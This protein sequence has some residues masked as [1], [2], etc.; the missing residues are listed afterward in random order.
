MK[1]IDWMN[2]TASQHRGQKRVDVIAAC[3]KVCK[4]GERNAYYAFKKTAAKRMNSSYKTI[5]NF[6]SSFDPSEKIKDVID[7]LPDDGY[8]TEHELCDMAGVGMYKLSR[9]KDQFTDNFLAV[10]D[11]AKL[12][13][14]WAK[15]KMINEMRK[16]IS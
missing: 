3:V 16:A 5:V 15:K 6:K 1:A 7:S 12:S 4:C 10:R 11:G 2:K 9:Y 8:I 13:C 14:F